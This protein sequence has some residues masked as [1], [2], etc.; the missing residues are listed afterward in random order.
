MCNL[1]HYLV[2]T[3]TRLPYRNTGS[4]GDSK[5][6]RKKMNVGKYLA[7]DIKHA[8]LDYQTTLNNTS[9]P[10]E[11][12]R[13]RRVKYLAADISSSISSGLEVTWTRVWPLSCNLAIYAT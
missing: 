10:K 1:S 13:K 9:G 6:K 8:I 4:Y 5:K 12:G 11:E 2:N 3:H 7:A